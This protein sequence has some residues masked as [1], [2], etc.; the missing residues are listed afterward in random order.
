M[1]EFNSVSVKINHD[2]L[3]D[4][5]QGR[6]Y[7]KAALAQNDE[8]VFLSALHNIIDSLID[9]KFLPSSGV[10]QVATE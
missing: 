7:L 8:Q 1:K 2:F 6:I 9:F 3:Q 5:E 10:S 4:P